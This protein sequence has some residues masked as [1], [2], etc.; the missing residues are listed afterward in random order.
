MR[1]GVGGDIAPRCCDMR[2]T[3]PLKATL[4]NEATAVAT[5]AMLVA[6]PAI[7][8]TSC[9]PGVDHDVHRGVA[10]KNAGLLPTRPNSGLSQDHPI[11]CSG[12][13]P[14]RRIA[15]QIVVAGLAIDRGLERVYRCRRSARLDL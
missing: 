15:D 12:L 10:A 13:G 3:F 14:N 9:A 8:L 7:E 6:G 2:L 1:T 11:R 4:V 5:M